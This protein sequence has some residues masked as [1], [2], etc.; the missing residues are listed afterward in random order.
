MLQQLALEAILCEIECQFYQ[1][2]GWLHESVQ[3]HYPMW[4]W[5]EVEEAVDEVCNVLEVHLG[6]L[7][8]Q[9]T[10]VR[11]ALTQRRDRWVNVMHDFYSMEACAWRL[12]Y[13]A[14]PF[15]T[16]WWEASLGT[17]NWTLPNPS[18]ASAEVRGSFLRNVYANPGVPR[19]I[20]VEHGFG[21]GTVIYPW[22][23]GTGNW[24]A[25][26]RPFSMPSYEGFLNECEMNFLFGAIYM[27]YTH[28]DRAHRM[29]CVLCALVR[30]RRRGEIRTADDAVMGL[31][32]IKSWVTMCMLRTAPG[33]P[34]AAP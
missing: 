25:L 1:G 33:Q 19:V 5:R 9:N 3:R 12:A 7:A 31:R 11:Q 4:D 2:H 28:R 29:I 21:N 23:H 18:Y 17:Y 24:E 27:A 22:Q 20:H 34:L 6:D 26:L 32:W 16:R 15:I 8:A 13:A 14:E 30:M 10:W